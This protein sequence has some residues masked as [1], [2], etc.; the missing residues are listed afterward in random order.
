MLK[1]WKVSRVEHVS[2]NDWQDGYGDYQNRQAVHYGM[3][4]GK[5]LK[6]AKKEWSFSIFGQDH[7]DW[8]F[9]EISEAR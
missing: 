5:N 2:T 3:T 7:S 8:I 4:L 9:E 1:M 6:D